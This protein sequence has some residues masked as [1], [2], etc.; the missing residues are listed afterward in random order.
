MYALRIRSCSI[1]GC[2]KM[3]RYTGPWQRGDNLPRFPSGGA[4]VGKR[5]GLLSYHPR[6]R[7]VSNRG[8][9][10]AISNL[11]VGWNNYH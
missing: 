4:L 3:R 1:Y 10:N 6:G 9:S 2:E 11:Q 7:A 5:K 8:L